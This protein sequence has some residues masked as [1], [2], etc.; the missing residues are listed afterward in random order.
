M[1]A[2]GLLMR[3]D[4]LAA[5]CDDQDL[6]A[7]VRA[8]Q[9]RRE[10]PGIYVDRERWRTLDDTGRYRL[11]VRGVMRKSR[12]EVVASHLSAVVLHRGP[13]WQLPLVE[14]HLT[15]RDGRSARRQPRRTLHRGRLHQDDVT[16]VDGLAVTSPAR[17]CVD[18]TSVVD[19]A[20]ALPVVDDFLRRQLVSKRQL[21]EVRLRM[22]Q[23]PGTLSSDVCIRL[24]D[25]TRENVAESRTFFMMYAGG[26]PRAVPQLRLELPDGRD[27]RLDFAWPDLGVWLEFD[28]REKYLKHRRPGESVVDAVLREKR[29][30]EA[31]ARATGWRCIRITWADLE[32]PRE[33]VAMILAVLGGAAI[34]A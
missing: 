6:R 11:V 3:A 18:L 24:A 22:E 13:T 27:V 20:H 32:R 5:G 1:T 26:V 30:E 8:K 16:V 21:E 2:D 15:R 28:G 10:L 17:T 7:A 4:A 25:G 12:A 29:R 19:T 34:H 14:V 31:I 33:T 23:W 9:L